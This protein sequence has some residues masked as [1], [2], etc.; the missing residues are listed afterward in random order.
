MCKKKATKAL[1]LSVLAATS[2]AT[3]CGNSAS[4]NEEIS[5][6]VESEFAA[7]DASSAANNDTE[8]TVNDATAETENSEAVTDESSLFDMLSQYD[9]AFSSGAGGWSTGFNVEKDGYFHGTYH[10]SEMGSTGDGYENGT[11]YYSAFSGH[12]SEPVQV[13]EYSYAMTILDISYED[14][15]DTEEIKNNLKYIYTDAYGLVGTEQFLVYLPGTPVDVFSEEVAWWLSM[16]YGDDTV[17]QSPVIVNVDQEE[18]IYSYERQTAAE[19]AEDIYSTYRKAYSSK[20]DEF[21]A[22]ETTVEM[23]TIADDSYAI[24]DACLNELWTLVKYNTDEA[25]FTEILEEQ[26]AWLAERD[27]AA[28]QSMEEAGTMAAVEGS[29][30]KAN[31]TMDRCETLLGYIE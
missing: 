6:N 5:Q 11:M 4:T 17:L 26:R 25:R 1:L 31:M 8:R 14:E 16:W 15:I 18:G 27:T 24:A 9:Y 21:S 23:E 7:E 28:E 19:E 20:T 3:A 13:D 2:M 29:L 22:A 10:D 12:F 30:T